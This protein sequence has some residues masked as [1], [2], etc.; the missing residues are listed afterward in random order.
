MNETARSGHFKWNLSIK[1]ICYDIKSFQV[2]LDPKELLLV[3]VSTVI[4]CKWSVTLTFSN[5]HTLFD[6]S[7]ADDLEKTLWQREK[8]FIMSNAPFDAMFST[9]FNNHINGNIDIPYFCHTIL[10]VVFCRLLYVGKGYFF[11]FMIF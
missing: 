4:E 6:K 10:K 2:S 9:S 7:A 3:I 1:D 11:Y 5:M 8:L